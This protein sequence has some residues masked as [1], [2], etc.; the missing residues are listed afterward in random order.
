MTMQ[1]DPEW[2]SATCVIL[3]IVLAYLAWALAREDPRE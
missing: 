2:L 3:I 1:P